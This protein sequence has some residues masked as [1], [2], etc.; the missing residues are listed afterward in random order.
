MGT[1]EA[2]RHSCRLYVASATDKLPGIRRNSPETPRVE[3]TAKIG[4]FVEKSAATIDRRVSV[5]PM[6]DWTDCP[7]IRFSIK[8]LGRSR[9][10]CLLYVSS[11]GKY[12]RRTCPGLPGVDRAHRD[13]R[14]CSRPAGASRPHLELN[15]RACASRRWTGE[16]G[17]GESQGPLQSAALVASYC[18]GE[19]QLSHFRALARILPPLLFPR[20]SP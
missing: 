5:A 14:A 13:G 9:A 17:E 11:N 4:I 7:R 20:P 15:T 18:A 16:E 8:A 3:N 10:P 6:M 1:S 12:C 2:T 19:K